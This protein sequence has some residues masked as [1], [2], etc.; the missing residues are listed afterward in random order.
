MLQ[1]YSYGSAPPIAPSSLDR[2]LRKR[3]GTSR[4]VISSVEDGR[5]VSVA[6]ERPSLLSNSTHSQSGSRS[7]KDATRGSQF[8]RRRSEG[9]PP[10]IK[11]DE[12]P[13]VAHQGGSVEGRPAW[14]LEEISRNTVEPRCSMFPAFTIAFTC[15]IMH[16]SQAWSS[17][18][19][20]QQPILI[21]A[22]LSPRKDTSGSSF[23]TGQDNSHNAPR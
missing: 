1:S 8:L 16:F 4:Q 14:F 2:D 22:A 15:C 21:A 7:P 9:R 13:G 11:E 19:G 3:H 18:N 10:D 12:G 20:P 5:T 6:S 17:P 23:P